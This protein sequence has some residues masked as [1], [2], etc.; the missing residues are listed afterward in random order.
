MHFSDD[1]NNKKA[2]NEAINDG[3]DAYNKESA[4][5]NVK[6]PVNLTT[7]S[8]FKYECIIGS[9]AADAV[10]AKAANKTASPLEY[11][12]VILPAVVF[13]KNASLTT[14]KYA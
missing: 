7:D 6:L 11:R 12:A 2:I 8:C 9:M 14:G 1:A 5:I 10:A 3:F 4:K 13:K